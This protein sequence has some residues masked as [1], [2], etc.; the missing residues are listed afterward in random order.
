M[1]LQGQKKYQLKRKS[2]QDLHVYLQDEI[3]KA[4]ATYEKYANEKRKSSPNFKKDDMVWLSMENIKTTRPM[5]KLSEKRTGPFKITEIISKNAVKLSLPV[6]LKK[7]HPV[8]HISLLEPY[9]EN[10]IQGRHQDPPPPIEV[11][12]EPE[13]EVEDILDRRVRRNKE[14][15]LVKWLGYDG[16]EDKMTWEPFENVKHLTDLLKKFTQQS[17]NLRKNRQ[18]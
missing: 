3:K 12:G 6:Y 7:I 17:G 10:T 8:F 14:E 2:L 1:I 5:K 9:I 15:Y 16:D 4:N 13:Y 11:D 18:N